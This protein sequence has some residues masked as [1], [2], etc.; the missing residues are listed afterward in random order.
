MPIKMKLKGIQGMTKKKKK[1]ASQQQQG[2]YGRLTSAPPRALAGG[3]DADAMRYLALLADPC[4]ATL[5]S[6]VYA[7]EGSGLFVRTKNMFSVGSSATDCLVQFCPSMISMNANSVSTYESPVLW[8]S[9]NATG[10]SLANIYGE[11]ISRALFGSITGPTM[12]LAGTARCVAACVKVHY[13]GSELNRAGIVYA[14][15][16][17]SPPFAAVGGTIGT[18]GQYGSSLPQIDR[19]GTRVH[20]YRWVPSFADEGFVN[21]FNSEVNAPS[22]T[23]INGGNALMVAVVGAPQG[24]LMFEVT[25]CWEYNVNTFNPSGIV[26]S[27]TVPRSPSTLNDVLR[28]IGDVGKFALSPD[29]GKRIVAAV[30]GAVKSIRDVASLGASFASVLL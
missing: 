3:R 9:S 19:L 26:S 18:A 10:T 20:E 4:N 14:G 1:T 23:T 28:T 30:S 7:G 8:A 16:Q 2:A 13:T 15:L 11:A 29:G 27:M 25:A 5:V 12:G 17:T 22:N 24:S 21:L 6:P